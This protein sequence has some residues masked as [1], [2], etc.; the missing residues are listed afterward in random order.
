MYENENVL[1]Y[2]KIFMRINIT[3]LHYSNEPRESTPATIITNIY[4]HKSM[5]WDARTNVRSMR[6]PPRLFKRSIE[7]HLLRLGG[8]TFTKCPKLITYVMSF[9]YR[10]VTELNNI[11]NIINNFKK[12]KKKR[13]PFISLKLKNS[14]EIEF[15]WCLS[16]TAVSSQNMYSLPGMYNDHIWYGYNLEEGTLKYTNTRVNQCKAFLHWSRWLVVDDW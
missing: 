4:N 15:T 14:F 9:V 16:G 10:M 13:K 1:I 7:L 5:L 8:D 3:A 2:H 11:K 6:T 12:N